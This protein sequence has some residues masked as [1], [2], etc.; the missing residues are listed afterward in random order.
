MFQ[1]LWSSNRHDEDCMS[2]CSLNRD[3][4]VEVTCDDLVCLERGARIYAG[5]TQ[6][7][8]EARRD[9]HGEQHGRN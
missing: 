3:E 4:I 8:D 1:K 2:A 5:R 7:G 6:S 9:G